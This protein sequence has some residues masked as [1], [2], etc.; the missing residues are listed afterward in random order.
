MDISLYKDNKYFTIWNVKIW[1]GGNQKYSDNFYIRKIHRIKKRQ[2]TK[3]RYGALKW[4][5]KLM[6]YFPRRGLLFSHQHFALCCYNI[7]WSI[8]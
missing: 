8:I 3:V 7:L 4:S 5:D 2:M 6:S 1:G